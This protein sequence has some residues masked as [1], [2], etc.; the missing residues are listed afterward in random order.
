MT[1]RP[2][3]VSKTPQT[4]PKFI[5][6]RPK[7]FHDEFSFTLVIPDEQQSTEVKQA[8]AGL[9][10]Q[11]RRHK[12]RIL[13]DDSQY[14][15]DPQGSPTIAAVSRRAGDGGHQTEQEQSTLERT[16]QNLD[17]RRD[18]IDTQ[19]RQLEV[20][21]TLI[22]YKSQPKKLQGLIDRTYSANLKLEYIVE[23]RSRIAGGIEDDFR[24]ESVDD[25]VGSAYID[26]LLENHLAMQPHG[27]RLKFLPGKELRKS[28][29]SSW[30][31]DI[32]DLYNATDP[33]NPDKLW[34][35]IL[36]A[37][38]YSKHIVA[39]HIV[40]NA[41]GEHNAQHIFGT[42][43]NPDH[44]HLYDRGN[45]ILMWDDIED[46]LDTARIAIGPGNIADPS[47]GPELTVILL[48][49]SIEHE[50]VIPGGVTFGALAKRP[51]AFKTSHRPRQ[52]YLYYHFCMAMLARQRFGVDSW[53]DDWTRLLHKEIW[54]SPSKGWLRHSSMSAIL[55][56]MGAVNGMFEAF[57]A[58][59]MSTGQ[60]K[61]SDDDRDLR[62]AL[63]AVNTND[64]IHMAAT[65]AKK[66]LDDGSTNS[67]GESISGE[68]GADEGLL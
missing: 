28:Q 53:Q 54:G 50:E 25:R 62:A 15:L 45:G 24:R 46:A 42:P 26:T 38:A 39:A 51:L 13:S 7:L 57:D 6:T 10:E 14:Y 19:I 4:N 35:P 60:V 67:D 29:H 34:C 64:E 21:K 63:A 23:N 48:D 11:E 16:L 58:G 44:G 27:A 8:L 68:E 43:K 47:A 61:S 5:K 36:H 20:A 9:Q 22:D 31:A 30:K 37:Y 65:A 55:K 66:G 32:I 52:R 18:L 40:P 49:R 1:P 59:C 41:L 3:R 17:T 33:D 12:Q 56:R 2:Q